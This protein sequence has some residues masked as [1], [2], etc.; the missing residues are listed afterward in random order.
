M[1][2][3]ARLIDQLAEQ[4]WAVSRELFSMAEIEALACEAWHGWRNG[5]F[6]QAAIGRDAQRQ[7]RSEIR[8]DFIRW[9]DEHA[10]TPAQT[11]YWMKMEQLKEALNQAL[12]VGLRELEA[13]YAVYPPGAFYRKHLDRF[14][15]DDARLISTSLYLNID[16]PEAA[17]GALRL[18]PCQDEPQRFVDV[19]PQ[20][21]TLVVFRS[22]TIYHEVLPATRMRLSLTGWFRRR[23]LRLQ[24]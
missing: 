3:F 15:T 7:V 6:L 12:F 24:A 5:L 8:G 10:L 11:S 4:H 9:L 2:L 18:Y 23:S 13:H 22:D 19:L 16:W 17:G 1:G 21:G 14:R 20:A